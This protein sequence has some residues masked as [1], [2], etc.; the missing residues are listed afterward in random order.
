MEG[1]AADDDPG[2]DGDVADPDV[3]DLL[4][5]ESTRVQIVT[6]LTTSVQSSGGERCES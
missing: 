6:L 5:L 2:Q 3:S 4:S 1:E